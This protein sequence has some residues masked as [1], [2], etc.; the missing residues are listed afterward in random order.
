MEIWKDIKGYEGLYQISNL[1]N[2][3]NIKKYNHMLLTGCLDK[4]GY[5]ITVLTKDRIKKTVKIHRLVAIAFISNPEGKGQV[6]HI[7]GDKINNNDWN[8]EWNTHS[9]NQLHAHRT[10]LKTGNKGKKC[11][12]YGLTG[13]KN[14]NS[15][16]IINTK[17][18]QTFDSIKEASDFYMIKY[19]VLSKNLNGQ[20][21]NK[22]DLIYI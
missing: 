3:K 17:T 9:E 5:K 11:S 18:N 4:D 21:I 13:S 16:K 1:G 12:F 14:I 15:R 10:G 7:D 6:N 2:I 22:T 19:N 8:L 20:N